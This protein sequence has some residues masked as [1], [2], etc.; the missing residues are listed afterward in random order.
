MYKAESIVVVRFIWGP[1]ISPGQRLSTPRASFSTGACNP[2]AHSPVLSPTVQRS[3]RA[4]RGGTQG[5]AVWRN[6]A[7]QRHTPPHLCARSA[8][9]IRPLVRRTP[10][11]VR[12]LLSGNEHD[13]V[14]HVANSAHRCA[15]AARSAREHAAMPVLPVE[16]RPWMRR[17]HA[18]RRCAAD[19]CG[20]P[21]R[22][23]SRSDRASVA[24]SSPLHRPTPAS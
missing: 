24:R 17:T 15:A 8:G 21:R 20:R 16:R 5:C 9:A 22:A 19:V 2:I 1:R 10:L 4:G 13:V 6:A 23:A 18:A 3:W 14:T 12:A 11:R 7:A